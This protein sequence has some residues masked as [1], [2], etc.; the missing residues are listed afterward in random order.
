VTNYSL[1]LLTKICSIIII[2]SIKMSY[3]LYFET[4]V[5][6]TFLLNVSGYNF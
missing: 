3:F 5:F 6:F 2:F 1:I 4:L